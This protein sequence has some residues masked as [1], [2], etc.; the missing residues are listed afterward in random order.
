MRPEAPP[1][2]AE[3]PQLAVSRTRGG[4]YHPFPAVK[5][6]SKK[7]LFS[8]EKP[9]GLFVVPDRMGGVQVVNLTVPQL[10]GL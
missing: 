7:P 8:N 3:S 10:P 6:K 1:R 4:P 9:L 5:I 2:R